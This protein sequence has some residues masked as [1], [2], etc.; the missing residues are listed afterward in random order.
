MDLVCTLSE[1]LF[2]DFS[3]YFHIGTPRIFSVTQLVHKIESTG[4]QHGWLVLQHFV[5][6][7]A[8]L[9][10]EFGE[11]SLSAFRVHQYEIPLKESELTCN[12]DVKVQVLED[13]E[14]SLQDLGL[15]A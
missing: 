12:V 2:I 11:V 10:K 13:V 7:Q 14:L 1:C 8:R 3:H 9:Q 6:D 4:S 15:G 5:I